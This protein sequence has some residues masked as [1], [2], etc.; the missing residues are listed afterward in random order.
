MA[1][2]FSTATLGL[3]VDTKD[4]FKDI[5]A[6]SS[7]VQKALDN[8][9]LSADAFENKWG[10]MTAGIKDTKRIV[11]GILV[12]QGFYALSNALVD[13]GAAAITFSKNMETAAISMEYF[14]SGTDKTAKAA[15][16]LRTMNTF[17]AKTPFSTEEALS[18]SKYMQAV[19]VSM[20]VTKSFLSVITDTAAATGATE[21]NLQRIVFGLGQMMTK[22]RL[23]N[24]EIRQLAN[25]NIPIYEI[26]QEEL[27]LTGKQISNIGSYW[28][29]ADKA[30]KAILDGLEARYDGAADR[31]SNTV[32][33]MTDTILDDAKIITQIVSQGAYSALADQMGILRDALDKYREIATTQGAGGLFNQILVDIDGTGKLGTQILALIGNSY[34]LGSALK[35]LYQDSQGLIS[36]FGQSLYASVSTATITFTS[37]ITV[38]DQVVQVLNEM[39]LTTGT[40]AQVIASL[41][42]AYKA[43]QWMALLGQAA[44]SVGYSMYNAAIS[45]GDLIPVT[46]GATLGVKALA[47]GLAGL[48]VYGLAVAG[49]FSMINNTMAG[50]STTKSKSSDLFPSDYT[51][52]YAAYQKAMDDYN[53]KIAKYNESFEEPYASID[54]GTDKA[55]DN[56][57]EVA[58][59]SGKAA[60]KVKKDW[61]AT[62]DEVYAPPKDSGAGGGGGSAA[63]KALTDLG[64]G[65]IAPKFA[66]PD[67]H[68]ILLPEM[69]KFDLLGTFSGGL[70]DIADSEVLSGD[71]WKALLPMLIVSGA[72]KAGEIIAK[73]R[74]AR[75]ADP[76]LRD[77]VSRGGGDKGPGGTSAF[78]DKKTANG[79]LDALNKQFVDMEKKLGETLTAIGGTK[80]KPELDVLYKKLAMQADEAEKLQIKINREAIIAGRE[81]AELVSETLKKAQNTVAI[82]QV[83]VNLEKLVNLS[84]DA[85]KTGL[86]GDA[87]RNSVDDI[88][89]TLSKQYDAF[90]ARNGGSTAELDDLL[91]NV[92]NTKGLDGRIAQV[93]DEA[94]EL[95]KLLMANG[96][97]TLSIVDR[98]VDANK[99]SKDV[100]AELR[101]LGITNKIAEEAVSQLSDIAK[102][103]KL[104]V[105]KY[106]VSTEIARLTDL[107]NTATARRADGVPVDYSSIEDTVVQLNKNI[108]RLNTSID[109]RK[110][111]INAGSSADMEVY[112]LKQAQ[113]NANNS[114]KSILEGTL[115][116]R[117]DTILFPIKAIEQYGFEFIAKQLEARKALSAGVE[118]INDAI[119]HL[120]NGIDSS[121][122][123]ALTDI[124]KAYAGLRF[125]KPIGG[126]SSATVL[127]SLQ[128][129]LEKTGAQL[130]ADLE[131]I[132]AAT[133]SIAKSMTRITGRSDILDAVLEQVRKA[134]EPQIPI[135]K[136]LPTPTLVD[137][138][139]DYMALL[140]EQNTTLKG[141]EKGVENMSRGLLQ[142]YPEQ[143]ANNIIANQIKG[144]IVE[145][146]EDAIEHYK[147]LEAIATF[148][149]YRELTMTGMSD[150]MKQ[151]VSTANDIRGLTARKV[152]AGIRSIDANAVSYASKVVSDAGLFDPGRIASSGGD[153]AG[154]VT[155]RSGYGVTPLTAAISNM[156]AAARKLLKIPE[157]INSIVTLANM[158][159]GQM[160]EPV[161]LKYANELLAANKNMYLTKGD[162]FFNSERTMQ[163]QIDAL[164]WNKGKF[165]A[166]ID[167]KAIANIADK[168]LPF[169]KEYA[170]LEEGVYTI[171]AK[172]FY[173][174]AAISDDIAW[175]MAHIAAV[176]DT[177]NTY[178]ALYDRAGG[179]I[180][181]PDIAAYTA[182]NPAVDTKY[183]TK[184]F[185]SQAAD[186]MI[187][188]LDKVKENIYLVKLAIPKAAKQ[189]TIQNAKA[190]IALEEQLSQAK[191]IGQD[192]KAM[193]SPM[194]TMGR[195]IGEITSVRYSGKDA[196]TPNTGSAYLDAVLRDITAELKS[197]NDL[198]KQYGLARLQ[199]IIDV[200][201]ENAND[202]RSPTVQYTMEFG[203][204]AYGAI[205]S[206]HATGQQLL[207][208]LP[209]LEKFRSAYEIRSTALT[210]QLSDMIGKMNKAADSNLSIG[211]VAYYNAAGGAQTVEDLV[212]SIKNT[213]KQ[214]TTEMPTIT[215]QLSSILSGGTALRMTNPVG[216]AD[217]YTALSAISSKVDNYTNLGVAADE[218]TSSRLALGESITGAMS[219]QE[220][221]ATLLKDGWQANRLPSVFGEQGTYFTKET[222]GLLTQLRNILA[223]KKGIKYTSGQYLK[224]DS[225]DAAQASSSGKYTSMVG[226]DG[227]TSVKTTSDAAISNVLQ[228]AMALLQVAQITY[229]T[230]TTKQAFTNNVLPYIDP[231]QQVAAQSRSDKMGITGWDTGMGAGSGAAAFLDMYAEM[232]KEERLFWGQQLANSQADSNMMAVKDNAEILQGALENIDYNTS[233]LAVFFKNSITDSPFSPDAGLT[234]KEVLI[235]AMADGIDKSSL[236][237]VVDYLMISGDTTS[238][239]A[240]QFYDK[241]GAYVDDVVKPSYGMDAGWTAAIN[242]LLSSSNEQVQ[243]LIGEAGVA[244]KNAADIPVNM[245]PIFDSIIL[246]LQ[247][248]TEAKYLPVLQ[249]QAKYNTGTENPLEGDYTR[250]LQ[251]VD[252]SGLSDDVST[253]LKDI[254]GMSFTQISDGL[255][256]V[257]FDS[258]ELMDNVS[259]WVTKLPD[260]IS[261][262]GTSLS[263]Q[264]ISILA[265]AGI[266]INGD[267]TVTFMKAMNENTSGTERAVD[268][269]ISDVSDN[270]TKKLADAGLTFDFS[271]GET[272]LDLSL[273]AVSDKMQSAMFKLNTVL[274]SDVS[275]DM[276]EALAGLGNVLDSG[277]FEITN[278]AVLNGEMT[279]TEYVDSMGDAAGDVSP[280]LKKAL[281]DIDNIIAQ[282]GD[283]TRA[284]VAEWA[285]GIVMPSPINESALTAEMIASFAAIG[286]TFE[287][288]A[289]QYMMVVNRVG[290]QLQ[291]GMVI[292]PSTTWDKLDADV[293]YALRALGVTTTE[294]AGQVMVDISGTMTSGVGNIIE[295]F[296]NRPDLWDQIPQ[297]VTDQLAAAG[298]AVD[299]GMLTINTAVMNGLV[300]VDSQ[301]FS[302]WS[303][304]P[305]DLI[306]S[307]GASKLATSD[308]LMRIEQ[309]TADTVIP[310]NIDEY[311][312]KPFEELP[313]D[314][315]D[316]LT[317][318][319]SS[320]A[321]S[322][323]GSDWI[324][325]GATEQAFVGAIQAV[326]DSFAT[327]AADASSGSADIAAAVSSALI[328]AQKLS[329]IKLGSTGGG[330]FGIGSTSNTLGE[331][332]YRKST[333]ITYY[334]E[335]S[336][337]GALVNYHYF[338]SMGQ[339]VKTKTIPAYAAGG[340]IDT[341]GYY[342]AGEFGRKEGIVPLENRNSLSIIGRTIGNTMRGQTSPVQRAQLYE[343]RGQVNGGVQLPISDG[344]QWAQHAASVVQQATA[345]QMGQGGDSRPIVY[346][347]TMIADKQGLRELEEKLEIIRLSK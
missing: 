258:E 134:A 141:F 67:I 118:A 211:D 26:L 334:P 191:L 158:A 227:T 144:A 336:K 10:T 262:D 115:G 6:T 110:A 38:A 68:D 231:T 252:F 107:M 230:V 333:G 289:G 178:L 185:K 130:G 184:V 147:A 66:F 7:A 46:S 69:P 244:I 246:Q 207:D 232:T 272:Q 1:N 248:A 306:D 18:L 131:T 96:Y 122:K 210:S 139:Q 342:R 251:N 54:D 302:T 196:A 298:I 117:L 228:G 205:D 55:I 250:V 202:G 286:V 193:V 240:T 105:S 300:N 323:A 153:Q 165:S 179:G 14:V 16:F 261:L 124:R 86:L 90:I 116:R 21:E 101:T 255:G 47:G 49:V 126:T 164:A 72:V 102:L 75:N 295:L 48:I 187:P 35:E 312:R 82:E 326:R 322:L 152:G 330:L 254:L 71:W 121:L 114:L 109:A 182:Y 198:V 65:L 319:D 281:K 259:G 52:Q 13:A 45:I 12:S 253:Q 243:A 160:Y 27:G 51:E 173:K 203:P 32:T 129:A 61:L 85:K 285:D 94:A 168:F 271:G 186:R 93:V 77:P 309:I 315:Q 22:G 268:L 180:G 341:D 83:K 53:A 137:Y 50:L 318:G 127:D 220:A 172:Y 40:T 328:N 2:T 293:V 25:A 24:E 171:S 339:E 325:T 31:V 183:L 154:L 62:F 4:F 57:G 275:S 166:P 42:I 269:T 140:Q 174:F 39:G 311:I 176:M 91:K 103:N 346:V 43:A 89:K 5:D 245:K 213:A 73:N 321:A 287:E 247:D 199:N 170:T 143:L 305:Q 206:F 33:G 216:F 41:F 299:N 200:L 74:K 235:K 157:E 128:Q 135:K 292:I 28:I 263:A 310:D 280:E 177:Q 159:Y 44:A 106:N 169:L 340:I 218:P 294:E 37:M 17:A 95:R 278:S 303:T 308:G 338:N 307:L 241:Y 320:V 345:A 34:Q 282:G 15:A 344:A 225:A 214:L 229:D 221:F 23:A 98:L 204:T 264:D 197:G 19:G 331:G 58:D 288:Q 279:M 304:M 60:D 273:A 236:A 175:Q 267:G 324:I 70:D 195:K 274:S 125:D 242:E 161:I 79:V 327:M 217:V 99:L 30:V 142:Q 155:G 104:Q 257:S 219:F 313:Q 151:L 337:D 256:K 81:G 29:S 277:Y 317:G 347:Q 145:A 150:N 316:K 201:K 149:N 249:A 163:A 148:S 120:P 343:A 265:S 59:A 283:A 189:Q 301:W 233:G 209:S 111:L 146:H 84:E 234:D 56:L 88:K 80:V 296:A 113:L 167:A 138:T 237:K 239:L 133:Q 92:L 224:Y 270:V 119:V 276:K 284:T 266:Q 226:P 291:D 64:A 212:W 188:V 192:V 100:L 112:R 181:K 20:N 223:E 238:K 297:S 132:Q 8:M 11:S 108:E 136:N 332:M 78:A 97:N 329:T 290:D 76:E 314:I 335:Y 190:F 87:A 194:N 3:G 123:D 36:L 215:A 162:T 208:L 63:L 9:K 260:T 156:S 222:N